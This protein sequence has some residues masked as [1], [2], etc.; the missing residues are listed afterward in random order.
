MENN[1]FEKYL[2]NQ[3]DKFWLEPDPGTFGRVMKAMK[4]EKKHRRFLFIFIFSLLGVAVMGGMLWWVT[5]KSSSFKN[6]MVQLENNGFENKIKLPEVESENNQENE[7]NALN[8]FMNSNTLSNDLIT[9]NSEVNKKV[10]PA[11]GEKPKNQTNSSKAWVYNSGKESSKLKGIPNNSE[12][13]K[14]TGPP[15]RTDYS[16]HAEEKNWMPSTESKNNQPIVINPETSAET[17]DSFTD[18]KSV[19]SDTS[20]Q[21]IVELEFVDNVTDTPKVKSKLGFLDPN[22]TKKWF[23]SAWFNGFAAMSMFEN[24]PNIIDSAI[25]SNKYANYRTYYNTPRFGF[26][27]GGAIGFSPIKYLTIELGLQYTEFTSL[28]KPAGYPNQPFDSLAPADPFPIFVSTFNEGQVY[29]SNFKM[30]QIPLLITFNWSWGKSAIHVSAGPTFSYTT[31]YKG[32]VVSPGYAA[33]QFATNVDSSGVQRIGIGI[34]S[35]VLYSYQILPNFSLFAGPTFQYRFNSLF[36]KMY[37]IRQYPYF[38]GLET[39]V[40]FHF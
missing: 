4:R 38:I 30:L 27:A 25:L 32:F 9:L 5:L 14:N 24:N 29:A 11:V 13:K 37:L 28:E 40:R 26:S 15:K 20:K 16:D 34:Q 36:D 2:R 35:K 10:H 22:R 3:A 8:D 1:D 6:G 17:K 19:D 33:L 23:V 7:L 18:P 12:A 21:E 39:G 31:S